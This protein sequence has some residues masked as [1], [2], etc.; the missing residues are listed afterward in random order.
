MD[1]DYDVKIESPAGQP[2]GH[3][4]G[5]KILKNGEFACKTINNYGARCYFPCPPTS[6]PTRLPTAFPTLNPTGIPTD[7]PTIS[8]TTSPTTSPSFQPTFQSQTSFSFNDDTVG[9]NNPILGV[10]SVALVFLCAL[11]LKRPV[12]SLVQSVSNRL[13]YEPVSRD[14]GYGNDGQHSDNS[15]IELRII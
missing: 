13:N 3:S 15:G 5:V 11:G 6:L 12:S 10:I 2:G 8:P 14:E 1:C 7:L 4:N 9:F